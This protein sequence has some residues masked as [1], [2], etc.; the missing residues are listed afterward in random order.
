MVPTLRI[1]LANTPATLG[2]T[3]LFRRVSKPAI[4][5]P[6]VCVFLF[7]CLSLFVFLTPA[8]GQ[9]YYEM[10]QQCRARGGTWIT[11]TNGGYCRFPVRPST[12]VAPPSSPNNDDAARRQREEAE[13]KQREQAAR[14]AAQREAERKAEEER[15]REIQFKRDRDET[16]KTLK[17]TSD[18][19]TGLKGETPT[20]D[21]LKEAEPANTSGYDGELKRVEEQSPASDSDPAAEKRLST[22][23]KECSSD[24]AAVSFAAYSFQQQMRVIRPVLKRD[25]SDRELDVVFR[26]L[27]NMR[28]FPQVASV[29]GVTA[30][31]TLRQPSTRADY[32]RTTALAQWNAIPRQPSWKPGQIRKLIAA[33]EALPASATSTADT[34]TGGVLN[35]AELEVARDRDLAGCGNQYQNVDNHKL[36][37]CTNKALAAYQRSKDL[38]NCNR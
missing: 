19:D 25:L 17:G 26:M 37:E 34:K 16:Y 9:W 8:R 30:P 27:V 21:G 36:A 13:R 15:Q 2:Q 12:T 14:E 32:V 23:L 7:I 38:L 33:Y 28:E 20:S 29:L 22:Y 18:N 1:P 6:S 3:L 4:L 35:C 24:Q 10:I 31:Q 11:T 5:H